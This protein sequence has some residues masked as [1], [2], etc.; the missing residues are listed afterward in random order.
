M[1]NIIPTIPKK[2][3]FQVSINTVEAIRLKRKKRSRREG[4]ANF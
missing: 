4:R 3:F 1:I 2:I